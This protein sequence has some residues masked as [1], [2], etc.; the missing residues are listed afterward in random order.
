[1]VPVALET[2]ILFLVLSRRFLVRF[3]LLSPYGEKKKLEIYA[4]F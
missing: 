2:I 4:I 3:S 1:M